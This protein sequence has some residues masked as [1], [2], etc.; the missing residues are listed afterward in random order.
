M[1]VRPRCPLFLLLP[2]GA[3]CSR[4]PHPAHDLA[5]LAAKQGRHAKLDKRHLPDRQAPPGYRSPYVPGWIGV[6]TVDGNWSPEY[7]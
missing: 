2:P 5:V 7:K 6:R 3:A 1:L 4:L